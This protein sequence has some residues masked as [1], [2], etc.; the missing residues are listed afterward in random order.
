MT[1]TM[2]RKEFLDL[3]QKPLLQRLVDDKLFIFGPATNQLPSA[4]PGES[5]FRR[6]VEDQGSGID[7]DDL[8][9][10]PEP[11]DVVLGVEI[12][13][14]RPG[15]QDL[16]RLCGLGKWWQPP[17]QSGGEKLA[18]RLR[19]DAR[20]QQQEVGD[21]DIGLTGSRR[22]AA[23]G[24]LARDLLRDGDRHEFARTL[25]AL[26]RA[27]GALP[28]TDVRV[29]EIRTLVAE[30]RTIFAQLGAALDLRRLEESGT[31]V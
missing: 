16:E 27:Y 28:P 5:P 7:D 18:H 6:V 26:A 19:V 22:E 23:F 4:K 8:V 1:E 29:R 12:E 9:L 30:A 13:Y 25:A 15:V 10:D 17:I 24:E 11:V 2:T 3:L 14:E 20:R 31:A 21:D